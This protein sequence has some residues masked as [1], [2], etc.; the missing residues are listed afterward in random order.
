MEKPT[1]DVLIDKLIALAELEVGVKEK[2]GNNNGEEI[3]KY[4][5][6]TWLKPASW[7]WCAAFTAY[8]L[9]RWL[10]NNLVRRALGITSP[11]LWRCKDASAF[12]WIKWA[13]KKGIYI[14]DEKELA[15]RGDFVVFDFS[16]IGIVYED[17]PTAKH[18]IKTIEGNTAPKTT[19]RDGN[20]DGV[21]KM[22]RSR[23]LVKAYIR[24]VK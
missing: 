9:N 13:T 14:T 7:A 20:N 12:G 24:I 1:K 15:K 22:E 3:R 11:E 8:I 10:Q 21:Y 18:K 19:Q 16:H 23:T 2:G 6:S 4:Q 17:Q 5:E